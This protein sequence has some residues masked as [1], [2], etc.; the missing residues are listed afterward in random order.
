MNVIEISSSSIRLVRER[1]GRLLGMDSWPIPAGADPLVALSAAPLPGGLGRVAVLMHHDDMLIRSLL[2]PAADQERLNRLVRFELASMSGDGGEATAISW[3]AVNV[4]LGDGAD[5]RVLALL[6]KP[7]LISRLRDC[8]AV[9]GGKLVSLI[10]PSLGLYRSWRGQYPEESGQVAIADIG[11]KRIHI[12]LVQ[13]G[14]LVFLRTQTPGMDDLVKAVAESR[15]LPEIEASK[16]V[17]R[18]GKGAPEDLHTLIGKHA[19]AMAAGITAAVRFAKA[20]LKMDTFEISKLY[21]SGAGAQVF[22]FSEALHE[23]LGIPV[24]II[25]PFSGVLSALATDELDRI[26]ALPSPW[27][28]AIGAALAKSFELDALQDE[29]SRKVQFWRTDGIL[30]VAM[31]AVVTLLVLALVHRELDLASA[32]SAISALK[33]DKQDGLVPVA[34]AQ[35]DKLQHLQESRQGAQDKLHWLDDQRRPGRIAVELLSAI[36]AQQD[37]QTCPVVLTLYHVSRIDHAVSVQIEGYAKSAGA[38]GT[39]VVLSEFEDGLKRRYPLISQMTPRTRASALDNQP[40]AYDI[41]LKD[42]PAGN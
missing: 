17:A 36:A 14:E 27:T 33:G 8:L 4:S 5:L 7:A 32:R 19:G 29:R 35:H 24:R 37:P 1:D 3:H 34:L 41:L 18:L 23:R 21:I 26:A 30:R 22:G 20:Q 13:N 42:D 11:G 10:P 2:Q 40:F 9:H 31:A 15:G 12:A 6:A 39:A 38:K 28:P 16:L 25:N